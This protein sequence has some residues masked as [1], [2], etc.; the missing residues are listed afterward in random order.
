MVKCEIRPFV[1]S[2]IIEVKD[3]DPMT[4]FGGTL[5]TQKEV[6]RLEVKLKRVQSKSLIFDQV[7]L[8]DYP[9]G[10]RCVAAGPAL[11]KLW[12]KTS[13]KAQW[14]TIQWEDDAC[15]E[16]EGRSRE[17]TGLEAGSGGDSVKDNTITAGRDLAPVGIGDFLWPGGLE[18]RR[19]HTNPRG[20]RRN[21]Q[22]GCGCANTTGPPGR[23]TIVPRDAEA[24]A[25]SIYRLTEL[26]SVALPKVTV[27]QNDEPLQNHDGGNTSQTAQH[28][29]PLSAPYHLRPVLVGGIAG[30]PIGERQKE[31]PA[32][33]INTSS[34][35]PFITMAEVQ[36]LLAQ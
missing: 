13:P 6:Q 19:Q 26:I 23:T 16:P 14:V 17:G 31:I 34:T 2:K 10:R 28:Q 3:P 11:G 20:S 7:R 1:Q 18:W 32:D 24:A 29:I 5:R 8:F 27:G 9:M 33:G 21:Q 22:R 15:K 35:G 25:R 30:N 36:A 12:V 4:H